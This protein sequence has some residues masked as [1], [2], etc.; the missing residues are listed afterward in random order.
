[1]MPS[2]RYF[3][4]SQFLIVANKT[5]IVSTRAWTFADGTVANWMVAHWTVAHQT[6]AHATLAQM[7]T[8]AHHE[9]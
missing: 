1:M 5:L 3:I 6:F 4:S 2:E 7:P 9:A 8:F